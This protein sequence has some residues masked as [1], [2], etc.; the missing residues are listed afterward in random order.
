[1]T[2]LQTPTTISQLR[3]EYNDSEI[4]E[5]LYDRHNCIGVIVAEH[6]VSVNRQSD[7]PDAYGWTAM[8]EPQLARLL[9]AMREA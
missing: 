5:F 9:T 1:M 4:A 3:D 7:D 2:S 6:G 8:D